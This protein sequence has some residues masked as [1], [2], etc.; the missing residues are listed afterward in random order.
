[1]DNYRKIPELYEIPRNCPSTTRLLDL[2]WFS[3][4]GE[5]LTVKA[6]RKWSKSEFAPPPFCEKAHNPSWQ[7]KLDRK[8]DKVAS[9]LQRDFS[10]E[11]LEDFTKAMLDLNKWIMDEAFEVDS[12]FVVR[13]MLERMKR[14]MSGERLV[15]G[16]WLKFEQLVSEIKD[17]SNDNPKITLCEFLLSHKRT[18]FKDEIEIL[19]MML[20]AWF[21]FESLCHGN[22][23][24]VLYKGS[25]FLCA[26]LEMWQ[27][28]AQAGDLKTTRYQ[29]MDY[30]LK[31][32][33]SQAGRTAERFRGEPQWNKIS[34]LKEYSP[35]CIKT[36][37]P[38]FGFGK[39][40]EM[41]SFLLGKTVQFAY[42]IGWYQMEM[43]KSGISAEKI[44]ESFG[45][46]EI[47]RRSFYTGLMEFA[48]QRMTDS[49]E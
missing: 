34:D 33:F 35:I 43:F 17:N 20:I 13:G 6:M 14:D 1:M 30:L 42:F 37:L 28:A 15:T 41:E 16:S 40:T 22:E 8:V 18:Q 3:Y 23:I 38:Y 12:S 47:V 46:I 10:D 9:R 44:V 2:F 11:E 29:V 26:P 7:R 24:G 39:L 49:S 19:L 45:R 5:P 36:V 31:N 27:P 48:E 25:H 4:Y 21:E 32:K